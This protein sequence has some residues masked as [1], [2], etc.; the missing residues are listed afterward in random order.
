MSTAS[1]D[2]SAF[3]ARDAIS[4]IMPLRPSI[5]AVADKQTQV[6]ELPDG[7][8]GTCSKA[9]GKFRWISNSDVRALR[10]MKSDEQYM[11]IPS[12]PRQ[13]KLSQLSERKRERR[14]RRWTRKCQKERKRTAERIGASSGVD[15]PEPIPDSDSL[16][17]SYLS[18]P[19]CNQT[20][21]SESDSF[22][23]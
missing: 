10:D 14:G 12:I 18:D 17:D 9:C 19:N 3:G 13:W 8:L 2:L 11:Q 4:A 15:I 23:F 22:A 6:E 5:L 20:H 16:S 7:H 1:L 21:E